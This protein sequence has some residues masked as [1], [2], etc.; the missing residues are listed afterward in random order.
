VLFRSLA[1][2]ATLP[3]RTEIQTLTFGIVVVTLLVFGLLAGP[4]VGWV[5]ARDPRVRR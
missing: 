4:F 1:L 5:L 3:D 2:P